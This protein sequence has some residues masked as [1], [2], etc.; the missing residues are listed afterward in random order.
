M[1]SPFGANSEAAQHQNAPAREWLVE[2]SLTLRVSMA[3]EPREREA[4]FERATGQ[5]QP[6]DHNRLRLWY[7]DVTT[8]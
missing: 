2:S 3:R 1:S 4:L 8:E 5:K 7:F 6:E